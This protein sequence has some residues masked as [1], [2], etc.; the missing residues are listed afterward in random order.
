VAVNGGFIRDPTLVAGYLRQGSDMA[1]TILA[2]KVQFTTITNL[3]S[4][5]L[6]RK[7]SS[8]LIRPPIEDAQLSTREAVV[9]Q[10]VRKVNG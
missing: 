6:A 9:S 3:A 1:S 2:Q 8:I 5:D 7:R 4:H 10:D